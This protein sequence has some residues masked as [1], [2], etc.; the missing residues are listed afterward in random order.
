MEPF[1]E[2]KHTND[3]IFPGAWISVRDSGEAIERRLTLVQE[4]FLLQKL[5]NERG[6]LGKYT[7]VDLW[8]GWI[9]IGDQ[10][11]RSEA[12]ARCLALLCTRQVAG[13]GEIVRFIS[14]GKENYD[15]QIHDP[16]IHQ[17][18]SRMRKDVL[19]SKELCSLDRRVHLLSWSRPPLLLPQEQ[20]KSLLRGS[21]EADLA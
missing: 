14:D 19:R 18:L 4:S 13:F 7:A 2:I 6:H 9:Y 5:A 11:V 12:L 1:F 17:Y 10:V 15:P 3:Q 8:R 16:R 21:L 20:F